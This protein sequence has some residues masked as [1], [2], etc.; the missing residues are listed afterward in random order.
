MNPLQKLNLIKETRGLI[1]ELQTTKNPLD[2]L[3]K[4][5]LIRTNITKLGAKSNVVE[6]PTQAS[7]PKVTQSKSLPAIQGK[8][9]KNA[10]N[11]AGKASIGDIVVDNTGNVFDSQQAAQNALTNNPDLANNGKI[12]GTD[13]QGYWIAL[14]DDEQTIQSTNEP[15]NALT[16]NQQAQNDNTEGLE[17]QPD[18]VEQ[19]DLIARFLANE[20][21]KEAPARFVDIMRDV[22]SL[23]LELPEIQ[24]GAITWL[25]NNKNK[26][27]SN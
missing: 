2:K 3:A 24:K 4:A 9:H 17:E 21:I 7:E 18:P 26:I 27:V 13:E 1:S 25:T 14:I 12:Q 15:T 19:K 20:F 6:F 8:I 10:D 16:T 22:H 23:G 5:K 11:V